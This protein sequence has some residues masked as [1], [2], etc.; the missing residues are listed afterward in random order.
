MGRGISDGGGAISSGPGSKQESFRLSQHGAPATA[1]PSSQ[2]AA[3]ARLRIAIGLATAGRP[4]VARRTLARLAMQQR[5]PDGI[6]VSVPEPADLGE[7]EPSGLPGLIVLTGARGLTR[8]RNAVLDELD[9]F[10]IVCFI[11][12]DFVLHEGYLAALERAFSGDPELIC[13]TGNVI[14]DGITGSGYD[15]A[16][17]EAMLSGIRSGSA[18]PEPVYNAYGC[19]M[20]FRL[21]AVRAGG[22]RFDERL[23]RYGWL[24]DVD[25]SR[26]IA[27]FGRVARL[28]DAIG[29]HLGVKGGRQSGLRFGYSQIANPVHLLRKGSYA[30]SRAAWLMGRN[31]AMNL[32]FAWRP[33]THIDRRGRLAGNVTALRDLLCGRLAPERIELLP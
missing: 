6:V 24:E 27:V 1:R 15:F 17:A 13:A 30:W 7:G 23:P 2:P 32:L 28:P 31:I 4:A 33:E 8:Q 22:L 12:D 3:A 25:F 18:Q 14:A 5:L 9:G 26:R 29:V 16:Q 19:N 11:D 20:A 21:S 10:D